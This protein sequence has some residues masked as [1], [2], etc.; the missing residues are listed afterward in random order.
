MQ[1]SEKRTPGRHRR[2]LSRRQVMRTAATFA[3]AAAVPRHVL[4]GRG[5]T[6]PSA[7]PKLAGIGVGGVGSGQLQACERAGFSIVALCD[8]DSVY[9]AKSFSRWPKARRYR[10]YR[11]MLEAESAAIDA[12]YIGTPDHTHAVITMA[13]LR[14]KKHICCV[15]PLTRTID[16]CRTVVA[17][18][19]AAGVATQVTAAANTSDAACRTCELIWAGAIGPVREAHVWSDRPFWPQGMERP[20]G[21]DAVPDTLDWDLWVGPSPMRPYKAEWPKDHYALR[22]V[23]TRGGKRAVYHPWNFRGWWDFGTG[24][25]GDMGCHIINTPYRALKLTHPT[26][27]QATATAVFEE[28]AP[29]ASLVT[30]D[31]PARDDMPPVRI[32]WYDG[33]LKPPRPRELEGR[34]LPPGGVLY[35]G[36][37]GTMLGPRILNPSRAKKAASVPKTLTRRPGTWSEWYAACTG[38]EPAGC[39]FDWAQ[40][41][42]EF[43]LL[44]T[45]AIRTGR[46]LTWDGERAQFVGNDKANRYVRTPYRAGWSL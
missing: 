6:P 30:Y 45:I 41:I 37:E 14:K 15:K 21:Q 25:L 16:E 5:Q 19:R 12:V 27:I 32:V 31:Y 23:K 17:A 29:L 44:G 2:I 42:T 33:G 34:P 3:A 38:G 22:Q 24:A 11:E 10:D 40:G 1:H 46:H 18:T 4:G 36:D 28:T 7:R 9:A 39:N 35:V 26:H 13:A 8:V 43:V 20:P